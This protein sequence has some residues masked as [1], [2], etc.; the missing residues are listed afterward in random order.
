[1]TTD[2]TDELR[3]A[4]QTLLDLADVAQTDLDTGDYWKPYPKATAWRD[5]L[6]NGMGGASGD[7][8]AVFSPAAA[9]AL[10]KALRQTEA[11]HT[12]TT[13]QHEGCMPHGCEW[14]G[15]EDWPC[16]D[17]RNALAVARQINAASA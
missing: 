9:H 11:L 8:A 7:L 13:C 5:G 14:C 6:T 10:A 1:M 17:L 16:A 2:P 4:A 3:Q 12:P 15:D